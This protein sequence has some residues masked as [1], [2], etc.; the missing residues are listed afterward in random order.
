M[1]VHPERQDL[2]LGDYVKYRTRKGPV[3]AWQVAALEPN[4]FLALRGLR[5]LR[6][7]MLDPERPRPSA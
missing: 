4:R 3:D 2:A 7:R 6:G 1:E 5:D